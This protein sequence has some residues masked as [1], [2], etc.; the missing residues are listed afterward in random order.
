MS[1][2]TRL[3]PHKLN[4]GQ[5]IH[6]NDLKRY[7]DPNVYSSLSAVLDGQK[8]YNSNVEKKEVDNL[9]FVD[10]FETTILLPNVPDNRLDNVELSETVW[11]E[12]L[13]SNTR[14]YGSK[15]ALY[16]MG[17]KV[18]NLMT[19]PN[20]SQHNRAQ[21]KIDNRILY[22]SDWLDLYKELFTTLRW[23]HISLTRLDIAIDGK[24][25][26][27]A[28]QLAKRHLT[29]RVVGRKGKAS[30]SAK[31][32]SSK[33]IISFHVGSSKSDK[34]ATIYNKTKEVANSDKA[35]IELAWKRNGLN[36]DQDVNRFEIRLRSKITKNYDWTKLDQLIYLSSIFRTETKNWFEFYYTGKDKNKYRT[37]KNN[38]MEWIKWETV[39]G[40][41]LPKNEAVSVTG[42][43]RAKR[44][45]KDSLYL[46]RVKGLRSDKDV[47]TK[48]INDYSLHKWFDDRIDNW[49]NEWETEKK[50]HLLNSN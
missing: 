31:Y 45:I 32:S 8:A 4:R 24:A 37:Y 40:E 47:I 6:E 41:L 14:L 27:K 2:G 22:R 5:L 44:Y 1:V 39:K 21:F 34:S 26:S 10:W 15:W 23:S 46:E 33:E 11:I 9:L 48:L 30:F 42:V 12:N 13:R 35:Y 19:N 38:T 49:I 28:L 17:E 25:S 16:Y 50:F 43:H 29:G 20:N 3:D 36:V 7:S 18:G